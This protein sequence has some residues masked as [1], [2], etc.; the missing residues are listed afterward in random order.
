[1]LPRSWRNAN[2]VFLPI[3]LAEAL[4]L[5]W[6]R[7]EAAIMVGAGGVNAISGEGF[8]P[9]EL[10]AEPQS[11]CTAPRQPW[12][13]GIKS[14]EGIVRQF[15]ATAK[16]SGASVEAQ[17]CGADFV[18]GLQLFVCPP[19]LQNVVFSFANAQD[20]SKV[21]QTKESSIVRGWPELHSTPRELGLAAGTVLEMRRLVSVV[22]EGEGG[23]RTLAD[24]NIQKESTLHLVLRLRGA[25]PTDEMAVGVGGAMRQDVYPDSKGPRFW[26][27]K[28]GQAVN[29]HLA[30]PAMYTAITGHLPPPTPVTAAEYTSRGYQWFSLY[31]EDTVND[32]QAPEVLAAVKSIC[33][34]GDALDV[35]PLPC[36][37]EVVALPH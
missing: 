22:R 1:M 11:Y 8:Q 19:K 5:S 3:H 35:D 7:K 37:A 25:V 13:D 23:G 4:W 20:A 9:G 34:W 31:D 6:N 30:G 29:V 16:G 14:G 27:T 2:D 21:T 33:E 18:G 32:V 28:A 36:P 26:D 12:L 17:V 15:V 24:Y 10:K